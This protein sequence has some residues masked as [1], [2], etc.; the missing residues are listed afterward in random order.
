MNDLQLQ[1]LI[2][3]AKGHDPDAFTALV[4]FYMKDLYRVAI[5]ILRN[6]ED[7][8]DAIQETI[9]TCWEKLGTLHQPEYFKTWLTRILIR[10]C[11]D[12]RKSSLQYTTMESLE[13]PVT[14]NPDTLEFREIL[15]HLGEKYSIIL[16]L[17]YTMGYSAAE[18]GK[19]LHLPAATV[20]TRLARGR[21]KL[22]DYYQNNPERS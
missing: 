10:H 13:E 11:Y 4:G 20:R 17:Y 18:I 9:L 19:L 3:K 15:D 5:S 7:A 2:H 1:Q 14:Y 16:T 8:A 22:K 21:K 6:D 12:I